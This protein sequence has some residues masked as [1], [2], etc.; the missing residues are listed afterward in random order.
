MFTTFPPCFH[1]SVRNEHLGTFIIRPEASVHQP[2]QV[3][4]HHGPHGIDSK[5][6]PLYGRGRR[7]RCAGRWPGGEEKAKNGDRPQ[8]F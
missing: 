6:Y 5:S 7:R 4:R 1:E 3:L 8:K 2:N